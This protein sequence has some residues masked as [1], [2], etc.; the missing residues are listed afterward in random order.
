MAGTYRT[1]Q[2]AALLALGFRPFFLAA[3]FAAIGLVALW[4]A[5]YGGVLSVRTYYGDI[6]WHGHEMVFGYTA[7]VIAGFLLT[8]VRNWTSLDTP[9]GAP[10]AALVGLWLAGRLAPFAPDLLPGWSIAALDCAFLPVL[11]ASL[12]GPLLRRRQWH[13][14]PFVPVLLILTAANALVH[15]EALGVF[16]GTAATGM[17]LGVD[18]IVLLI[19]IIGGRVLPFFTE[20]ALPGARRRV[21]QPVEWLAIGAVVALALLRAL[22]FAP[23]LITALA[24]LAALAHAVRWWGWSDRRLWSEPMLWVLYLGYAWV[25]VGFALEALAAAALLRQQLAVHAFTAGAIGTMTLGMMARVALGHT[26]RPLRATPPVV[27]A[28]VLV[29]TAALLRVFAAGLAADEWYVA[30]VI[31]AGTA[32]AAAFALFVAVYAPILLRP[33]TDGQPG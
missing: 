15:L 27:A 24:T 11:A 9:R 16:S 6:N 1:G 26:G 10:L 22:H 7:A 21:W 28:F 8:A 25:I 32:W 2:P 23:Y 4:L 3:A 18:L 12:A 33:R 19:A 30:I 17:Y 29:N 31:A 5:D 14:L 13:N 20:R